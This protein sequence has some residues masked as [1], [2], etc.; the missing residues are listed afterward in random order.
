MKLEIPDDEVDLIVK[1]LEHYHSYT[2]AT[3]SEYVRSRS[4]GSFSSF[5]KS[6]IP[7][8]VDYG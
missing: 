2:V 1:A 6:G 4:Y 5:R 3:K 7:H 8:E